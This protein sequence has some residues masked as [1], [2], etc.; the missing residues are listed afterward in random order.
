M[1]H[2]ALYTMRIKFEQFN[3]E[4]IFEDLDDNQI[5]ST[6]LHDDFIDKISLKNFQDAVSLQIFCFRLEI[7]CVCFKNALPIFQEIDKIPASEE[8]GNILM[9]VI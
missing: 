8:I 9:E 4:Y 6:D 3:S 5:N 7:Y 1:M 2:V